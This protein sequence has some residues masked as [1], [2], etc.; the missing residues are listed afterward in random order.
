MF[1]VQSTKLNSTIMMHL[2]DFSKSVIFLMNF[3]DAHFCLFHYR[4]YVLFSFFILAG[5]CVY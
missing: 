3:I 2:V 1:V 4:S 5:H